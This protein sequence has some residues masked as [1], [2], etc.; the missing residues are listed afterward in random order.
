MYMF[1]MIAHIH[2]ATL[3]PR[4]RLAKIA[5]IIMGHFIVLAI[6]KSKFRQQSG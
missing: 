5:E 4:S 2:L 3:T 1:L 6:A